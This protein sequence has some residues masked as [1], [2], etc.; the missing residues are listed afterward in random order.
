MNIASTALN[1]LSPIKQLTRVAVPITNTLK[2]DV[3]SFGNITKSVL[4]NFAKTLAE[5]NKNNFPTCKK[6]IEDIFSTFGEI[7]ARPK[8]ETSILAKLERKNKKSPIETLAQAKTMIGDAIGSRLI[9]KDASPEK[10]D[11]VV[12]KMAAAIEVGDLLVTEIN[13]YRGKTSKAYFTEEQ[14]EKIQLAALKKGQNITVITGENA[15]KESGYTTTQMNITH[16]N[17]AL[18]EFQIRG[19]LINNLGE[20]EHSI[21]DIFSGKQVDSKFKNLK[22]TLDS[23][24]DKQKA[25]YKEYLTSLFT[26][27]RNKES[28]VEVE[29]PKLPEGF[30][31]IVSFENL[32]AL[33][34]A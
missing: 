16:K 24:D 1:F 7:S 4:C 3:V 18:G 34:D 26:Y 12:D 6:E 31:Q 29:M 9:L 25:E 28:G 23:F 2:S 20:I 11:A 15:V 21:Y 33:H 8:G 14:V 5:I 10:M 17:G 13:N 30:P 27:C 22:T 19:E 32:K